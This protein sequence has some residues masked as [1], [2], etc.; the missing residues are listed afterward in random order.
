MKSG[1]K[2]AALGNDEAQ[3]YLDEMIAEKQAKVESKRAKTQTKDIDVTSK[4]DVAWAKEKYKEAIRSNK[5]L[6]LET[7]DIL[8]P[9]INPDGSKRHVRKVGLLYGDNNFIGELK[10][11]ILICPCCN[12]DIRF[13]NQKEE[14]KLNDTFGDDYDTADN[15]E[16]VFVGDVYRPDKNGVTITASYECKECGFTFDNIRNTKETRIIEKAEDHFFSREKFYIYKRPTK[17]INVPTKECSDAAK[18]ILDSAYANNYTECKVRKPMSKKDQEKS[19]FWSSSDGTP[20][21]ITININ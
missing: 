13:V 11:T 15:G 8:F 2:A 10:S 3:K 17:I 7:L 14:G 1:K 20:P 19:D 6:D 21:N 4:E 16:R 9:R 5:T 18:R 12:G